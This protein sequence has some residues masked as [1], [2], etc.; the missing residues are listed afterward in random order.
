MSNLQV[1]TQEIYDTRDAFAAVLSDQSISFEREA[2]FAIQVLQQNDFSLGVAMKNR[3]S[4][5]NAITNIAAIGISLNPAKKQAY[6]VP[7]D[8]R[9]C[10]D[11]SYMGLIDLAVSTG[12]IKWAQA[13]LVHENDNFAL[14][15][16]DAPP[17]HV[18]NPFSK[19]R[20][21]IV[22]AY[23]VAKTADGDYLTETMSRAD[24]DGIMNRSQSVKSGKSSPWKT[25]Y[26]EMAK[27]TVVKR[28][29]KYW[30][31][32]DRLDVA[33]HHLNTDG[34]E[35]IDF[36]D[37]PRADPDLL[38]RL[39]KLVDAAPDTQALTKVWT[40]GLAEVKATK[41]MA[42]Y[43]AF[44]A[45]VTQRGTILRGEATPTATPPNDGKTI[46]EERAP[47]D[48]GFGQDTGAQHE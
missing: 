47:E 1:I 4:V 15:G 40:D 10:L 42:V 28:A 22:G 19:D 36:K 14:N 25:D 23:V 6:L 16:Y 48:E 8:G 37:T 39:R 13:N 24:I 33:T 2:G 30:P 43:N 34:G 5:I 38:P 21:E 29:S 20:G 11:I 41:D 12:S 17:T 44:K 35:G 31:K 46:D 7:R 18:F 3:Q 26:G 27:K 32:T 45:Y 9:I